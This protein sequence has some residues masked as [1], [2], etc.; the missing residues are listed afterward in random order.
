[1]TARR[2][3]LAVGATALVVYLG[4]LGN[5]FAMDDFPLIVQNPLV[6][7]ASG[8][9]RAFVQPYWPPE[10]GGAM[11]RPLPLVSWTIDQRVGSAPWFHAI[12]VLWHVVVCV[13]VAWL[14]RRL[15]DDRT[16]LIAG[17]LFAVHPVH[18][19]AV[20]NVVGR[21]EPMAAAF[22]LLGVYAALV[23]G[24]VWWTAAAWTL[25]LLCKENAAVLPG[26][27]VW[28]WMLGFGRPTRRRM[29][30]FAASWAV[31]ASLYAVVRWNVLLPW[32][33]YQTIAPTFLGQSPVSIR[34][35]A[36]AALADVAR[37]LVFPLRLR[38]DYSPNE[39]TIIA[40]VVSLRVLVGVACL[41]VWGML[42]G[43]TWRRSRRMEA[44]G[45]GWIGIAFLPV[46]NLVFPTGFLLAERTL[47][48]PSV[49]LVLAAGSWLSRWSAERRRVAVALLVVL[50]AARTALRVPVWRDNTTVTLSIIEDSPR[51][52]VGPKR[53]IV[54]YLDL[55][56]PQ[57]ALDAARVA[58][59][60][61]QADPTIYATGAVAAFAARQPATADSLLQHLETLCR[62]CD[63]YYRLE[64]ATAR[65]HGY[66]VAAESLEARRQALGAR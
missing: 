31:V 51:S 63:G 66:L 19:E 12:T 57:R 7:S 2:L 22:V 56:Q 26:L 55:H 23:R 41:L 3:Y 59:G 24:S 43:L 42:L 10:L 1:V 53:M 18:V 36:V 49:G 45:L 54:T 30:A 60:I 6:Q 38:A 4:A 8:L 9:W 52:Y 20:A 62:R 48:L 33:R 29:L 17:L 11:Y 21:A 34:L 50:G 13:L 64:A 28:G 44:F 47:Y 65:E 35:T 61:N 46:A 37:V 39:R 27:V 25:G 5:R 15:A 16:A 14:A 40:S 58:A 32:T